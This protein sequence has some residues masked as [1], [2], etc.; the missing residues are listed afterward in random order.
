M[1]PAVAIPEYIAGAAGDAPKAPLQRLYCL[2]AVLAVL[3]HAAVLFLGFWLSG[4]TVRTLG[5]DPPSFIA[6]SLGYGPAGEKEAGNQKPVLSPGRKS[7]LPERRAAGRNSVSPAPRARKDVGREHSAQE[8][9]QKIGRVAGE[10]NFLAKPVTGGGEPAAGGAETSAG[11]G[12]YI[13]SQAVQGPGSGEGQ[14]VGRGETAEVSARPLYA[15]NPPLHYPRLAR[16]MG[17]QGVV[18][19]EVVVSASGMVTDVKVA[20]GSGSE[21]LDAA[22][23]DAVRGW[24]F[25]PGLRNGRPVVMRVRV[26]VRFELRG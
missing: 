4:A 17:K 7:V 6:V 3:L 14:E 11:G 20:S 16:R 12:G 18:L 1:R 26:P 24:R 25:A 15:M 9:L 2:A 23:L 22:A 13:P 19:L 10:E 5:P 8:I 21:L